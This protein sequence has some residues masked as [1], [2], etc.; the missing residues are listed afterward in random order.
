MRGKEKRRGRRR[1]GEED[2]H[3]IVTGDG[4]GGR[5]PPSPSRPRARERE[6]VRRREYEV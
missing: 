2:V 3:G 6:K 4:I 5:T 1:E